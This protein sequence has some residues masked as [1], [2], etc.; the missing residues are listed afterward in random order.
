MSKINIW[1]QSDYFLAFSRYEFLKTLNSDQLCDIVKW[2]DSG[3]SRDYSSNFDDIVDSMMTGK[4]FEED[5]DVEHLEV[6]GAH[7]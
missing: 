2:A 5:K 1:T 6:R 4:T 3:Y 7:E